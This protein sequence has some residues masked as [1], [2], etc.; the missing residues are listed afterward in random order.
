LGS[1]ALLLYDIHQGYHLTLLLIVATLGNTLGSVVNYYLGYKG[2]EYLERKGYLSAHTMA[3]AK[4]RFDR[5]GGW[6]LL[7]AWVPI[8]GD[9]ITFIA[10]SLRYRFSY[11]LILVTLSKA[12]RYLFIALLATQ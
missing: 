6:T 11:F 3:K 10:G 2:E 7:L 4:A 12:S 5:Y 1:E 8:I 9:P